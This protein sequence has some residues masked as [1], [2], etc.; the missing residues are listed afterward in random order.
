MG[1]PQYFLCESISKTTFT[2]SKIKIMKANLQIEIT[3][4]SVQYDYEKKI[5]RTIK[6]LK[7]IIPVIMRKQQVARHELFLKG[8]S[9]MTS[10]YLN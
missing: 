10:F 2:T 7:T 9:Q 3:M 8:S 5:Q 4:Y 6:W 1:S